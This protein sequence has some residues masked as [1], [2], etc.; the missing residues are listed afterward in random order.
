M[1]KPALPHYPVEVRWS[2]EDAAFLAEVFDLPGCIADGP[3]EAKAIAAALAAA[4]DW[5]AVANREKRKIPQPSSDVPASGKFNVR[6]PSSLHRELQR[7]AR[8]ERVSL[9]Q[10]ATMLLAR[11]ALQ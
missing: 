2:P 3:T 11:G 5:L 10:L 6:I 4:R 8:R 1:P 9:N 7:R